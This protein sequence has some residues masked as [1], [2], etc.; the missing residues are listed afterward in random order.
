VDPRVLVDREILE[1]A[2]NTI[3]R[4]SAE[5]GTERGANRPVTITSKAGE[6]DEKRVGIHPGRGGE[7]GC[8][9][10]GDGVG[11]QIDK[12]IER[13]ALPECAE[14]GGHLNGEIRRD[15]TLSQHGHEWRHGSG[16]T[17]LAERA[18]GG[19]AQF[20]VGVPAR[21]DRGRNR[22]DGRLLQRGEPPK[23]ECR[24]IDTW[25]RR[26]DLQRGGRSPIT[27]AL[28]RKGDR[29]PL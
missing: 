13:R 18:N 16:A 14:R 1:R 24:R 2:P 9:H 22:H 26:Q 28:Q 8:A 20:D 15:A 6:D 11:H 5:D 4:Q 7:R 25:A 27:A 21:D 23:G 29:P 3:D 19:D 10:G 12:R 17:H